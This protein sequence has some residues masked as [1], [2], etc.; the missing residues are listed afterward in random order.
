VIEE[1]TML[2]RQ[3]LS[4]RAPLLRLLPRSWAAYDRLRTHDFIVRPAIPILFFGDSD[5]YFASRL[6]VITVGLNP[7]KAEFPEQ[8]RFSRFPSMENTAAPVRRKPSRHLKALNAYFREDPYRGWFASFEPILQGLDASYYGG[9]SN[10]ALHTD[11]CSPVATCRNW[12]RL[13][14]K[15]KNLLFEDGVALWRSLVEVLRP[16]L[17]IVSLA[18]IYLQSIS[19][20]LPEG[21][22][23]KRLS[24]TRDG[25]VRNR[26]CEVRAWLIN[27]SRRRVG[28]VFGRCV[29]K[30]FGNVAQDK[31]P[32]VGAAIKKWYRDART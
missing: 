18:E 29:N 28:L 8:T 13:R 30:P 9:R 23:I 32:K 4:N 24:R 20:D 14:P 21:R 5:R 10:S 25:E 22:V 17:I 3:G 12:S 15:E 19:R 7:S 11:L 31:K 16:H 26:P 27:F 1:S 2:P 6:R